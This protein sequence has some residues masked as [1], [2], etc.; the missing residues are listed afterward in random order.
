MRSVL[1]LALLFF[2][3]A[4]NAQDY[5]R[6]KRWADQI[7]PGLVVG[8]AVWIA[9]KNG[10]KFLS[11]WTEAEKPRGAIILAHGRGWN[12][13]FELYGVLRVKLG[14]NPNSSSV[15][16]VVTVL[17]WSVVLGSTMLNAM[18]ALA[19]TQFAGGRTLPDLPDDDGNG[20]G[21][22]GGAGA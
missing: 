4:V 13:D 17:M 1:S 5:P 20:S 18:A 11:L 6:E 7:V 16:S 15:G 12:P 22:T 2:C 9:Q 21:P 19:R 14:Y 3:L 10:H 8:E